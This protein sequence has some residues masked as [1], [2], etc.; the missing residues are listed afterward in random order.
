MYDY[1]EPLP[2]S[3]K[4]L[5]L[6]VNTEG[7]RIYENDIYTR[8]PNNSHVRAAIKHL[9]QDNCIQ[10]D[11]PGTQYYLMIGKGAQL[12]ASGG[13]K[14]QLNNDKRKSEI[15]EL[16]DSSALQTGNSVIATNK[17]V[18]DTNNS[19][20]KLNDVTI[21][22]FNKMQ[23]NLT[24]LTV[25]IAAL[26]CG[27]IAFSAYFSSKSITGEQLLQLNTTLQENNRLLDSIR[28]SQ[29]EIDSSLRLMAKDSVRKIVVLKK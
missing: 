2:T 25:G 9:I 6:F 20:I 8:I 3:D 23:K 11:P 24:L 27:A 14:E 13:Y 21:P 12:Y 7:H 28:K 4:I 22:R 17:S 15:K 19:I 1:V 10:Y 26:S 18:S 29:K 16:L 5:A